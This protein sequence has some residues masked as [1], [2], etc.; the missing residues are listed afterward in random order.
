MSSPAAPVRR[1][2]WLVLL[3]RA[4]VAL[5][6]GIAI[7]FSSDHS[8]PVGAIAFGVF[9]VLSGVVTGLGAPT[10][11][12]P[13]A[14]LAQGIVSAV[15]GVVALLAARDEL[16]VLLFVVSSWAALTGFIE[17]Y[18]GIRSRGRSPL[19]RE[20]VFAGALTALLAVVALLIPADY[21]L[22][23]TGPDGIGRT[24]TGAVV[25]V[26]VFGAYAAILGVYLAIAALSLRWAGVPQ[27]RQEPV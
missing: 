23:F 6:V 4:V 7:T 16:A 15:A 24:L 17:L 19:A 22:A 5:A 26:G 3:G 14:G 9:G 10:A 20:W 1:R 18:R 25:L 11:I 8:T 13:A 12:V 21:T 2:A 27:R